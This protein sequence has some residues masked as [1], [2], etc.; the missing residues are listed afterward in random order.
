MKAK[1]CWIL[2]ILILLSAPL[3][4]HKFVVLGGEE[5]RFHSPTNG[6]SV[7]IPQGWRQVPQEVVNQAFKAGFAENK[8]TFNIET[9]LAIEF[10]ENELKHPYAIIQV[11]SYSKYGVNQPLTKEEIEEVFKKI[12]PEILRLADTKVENMDEFLSEG[13]RGMISQME[14]GKLYLD[15]ENMS[16]LFGI[17][18]EAANLG[19]LKGLTF[20]IYGR[21]ALVKITFFCLESDWHRFGKARDV[22]L[23]SFQ[24]DAETDY[25]GS[26]KKRIPISNRAQKK[27]NSFWEDLLVDVVVYGS[28][29][30]VIFLIGILGRFMS[31]A[32]AKNNDGQSKDVI[33]KDEQKQ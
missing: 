15:N 12:T 4:S 20:G 24:F 18:M 7:V 10:N 21:Y 25:K 32:K 23:H 33:E 17:D 9:V 6:Y 30:F 22:I 1:K 3:L 29:G 26:Q 14:F 16:F 11:Q 2:I 31:K 28:I 27:S 13:M 8:L 5:Q 19:R